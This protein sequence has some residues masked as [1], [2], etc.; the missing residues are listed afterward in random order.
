MIPVVIIIFFLGYA[1]IVLEEFIHI[2]KTA[3]ALITGILC[4]V[5]LVLFP[6]SPELNSLYREGWLPEVY[7]QLQH[8]FSEISGI[9]F[10]LLSAMTIV[11]LIDAHRGFSL[12]TQN[13]RTRNT[14]P[15]LWIIVML[16]FFLSSVLDNLTTSIVMI[17]IVGKT[18]S[19]QKLRWWFG[20]AIIIAANAGGA[21]SPIGD[22]TT[23]MLWIGG[24]ISP[25]G[26]MKSLFLP[27]VICAV[28]PTLYITWQLKKAKLL[29]IP[30]IAEESSNNVRGRKSIFLIGLGG[31]I[32][33]P[34][35]KSITHL[36]PVLGIML[37]L[38]AIWVVTEIIH[39]RT[40]FE[41]RKKLTAAYALSR[42]DSASILFFFGILLAIGALDLVGVLHSW[43]IVLNN[44]IGNT[45][46][47]AI[48]IGMASAVIDNVPL[49]AA[50]IGMYS[51]TDF[52]IDHIFWR[53]LA[54]TT[55]T[56]GSLL[57]IGSAAGV[58]VMAIEKITFIW[59]LKHITIPALIGFIAGALCFIFL[60]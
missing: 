39:K 49:V 50:S 51:L 9:L 3:I 14:I 17:T 34:I 2:N 58:A 24:Q 21:W 25:I 59:F 20:G 19:N 7:K 55:G 27:S 57:I 23:T 6:T 46:I 8:Q 32:F 45:E 38:G 29:S 56:G 22:V 4:W 18:I 37:S 33:V 40:E 30:E 26:V 11:E 47:I 60:N 44:A 28:L 13:I 15:F 43:A 12:I 31:L 54:Y 10:F 52:P 53:L 42:I 5:V 35:F 48:I 16:S 41:H 1:L 36:P